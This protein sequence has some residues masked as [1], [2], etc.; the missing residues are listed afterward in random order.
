MSKV[1]FHNPKK[2][3]VHIGLVTVMPG[4]TRDVDPRDIPDYK[5][6]QPA[7]EAVTS[8]LDLLDLS[9]PKIT[10]YLPEVSSEELS[11]L[12]DAET[13]GNTRIGV[14]S[15]IDAEILKRS[16]SELDKT[17][18]DSFIKSLPE[19]SVAELAELAD[20]HANDQDTAAAI[21]A[22]FDTRNETLRVFVESLPDFEVKDLEELRNEYADHPAYV[23]AINAEI[24]KQDAAE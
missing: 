2:H 8:V 15:A 6:E 10:A 19:K 3:A 21:Q 4:G 7:A 23:D 11:E 16:S 18:L 17:D 13:K 5:A 1:P 12:R 14:I 22:E 24:A 20:L 9:I